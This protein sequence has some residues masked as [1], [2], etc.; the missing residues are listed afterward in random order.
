MGRAG[1]TSQQDTAA[2]RFGN[3][4]YVGA[5][6]AFRHQRVLYGTKAAVKGPQRRPLCLEQRR[7][8][9]AEDMPTLVDDL[10]STALGAGTEKCLRSARRIVRRAAWRQ[11]SA[12]RWRQ[13]LRTGARELRLG[14]RQRQPAGGRPRAYTYTPAGG[15]EE[16]RIDARADADECV[17]GTPVNAVGGSALHRKALPG[18]SR[19]ASGR[20]RTAAR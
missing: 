19:W 6:R 16:R 10:P 15:G 8:D 20:A 14:A 2:V 1:G 13:E 7:V 4:S 3:A 5:L 12:H 18:G 17:A 9:G 11:R